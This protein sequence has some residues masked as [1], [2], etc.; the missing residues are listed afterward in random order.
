LQRNATQAKCGY[1]TRELM[2]AATRPAAR[3]PD[4]DTLQRFR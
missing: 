4:G 3:L 1:R 2:L